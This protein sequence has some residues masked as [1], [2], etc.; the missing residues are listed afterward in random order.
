[1]TTQLQVAAEPFELHSETAGELE[2]ESEYGRRSG[3]GRRWGGSSTRGWQSGRLQWGRSGQTA[4]QRRQQ[5]PGR[6]SPW[7]GR[8]GL[9]SGFPATVGPYPGGQSQDKSSY[10]SPYTGSSDSGSPYTF[11]PWGRRGSGRYGRTLYG[12]GGSEWVGWAQQCLRNLVGPSVPQTGR[13]SKATRRAIRVFQKRNRLPVTGLLD[14]ATA[15]ALRTACGGQAPSTA[16]SGPPESTAPPAAPAPPEALATPQD[17]A[18]PEPPPEDAGADAAP[19]D[20]GGAEP[21]AAPADGVDSEIGEVQQEF[22]VDGACQVRIQRHGPVPLV[23]Q[24][25]LRQAARAPGV[26][27]VSVDGKPWYVGIAER[28]V[29]AR[30]QERRKVLRDFNIPASALANRSVSWVAIRGGALPVCAISR[31][32]QAEPNDA[33]RPLKGVYAVLKVL[34][35]HYIRTLGTENKGNKLVEAVRFSPE[36]SI[37]IHESGKGPVRLDQ[38]NPI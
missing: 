10:G 11:G 5:A 3:G 30:I 26:Y 28:T 15:A 14:G 8:A 31:R 22:L 16:D 12:D 6:A 24:P 4:L 38:G 35:Q 32:K 36:G 18:P 13:M 20:S 33:F 27:I 2:A 29:L 23:D 25:G 21:D 1:M 34:E 7:S 9:Q 17:A 37:T 19:A